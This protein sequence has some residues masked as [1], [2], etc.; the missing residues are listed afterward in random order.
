MLTSVPRQ[1]IA[2]YTEY[3]NLLISDSPKA[4][5]RNRHQKKSE[6]THE[7]YA[8]PDIGNGVEESQLLFCGRTCEVLQMRPKA[9]IKSNII[10][11]KHMAS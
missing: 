6:Q 8:F 2:G 4:H 11:S 3:L 5:D 7:S 10:T 9:N 1:S